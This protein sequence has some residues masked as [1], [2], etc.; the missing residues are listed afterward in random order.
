ME[1]GLTANKGL[2]WLE[3]VRGPEDMRLEGQSQVMACCSQ[4]R[5]AMGDGT[6]MVR[7]LCGLRD[8]LQIRKQ[9]WGHSSNAGRR[10]GSRAGH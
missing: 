1:P 9:G 2:E 4:Q 8:S 10:P 7:P 5:R 3:G 6:H